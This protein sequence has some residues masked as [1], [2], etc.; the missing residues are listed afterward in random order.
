WIHIAFLAGISLLP[1]STGLVSEYATYRIPFVVYWLNLVF[2]GLMLLISV[3]YAR[4]AGLL[5]AEATQQVLEAL[6][7]RIYFYQA[8]Y[9]VAVALCGVT[10][11]ASLVAL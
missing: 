4:R 6:R 3:S 1:F 8:C 10:A 9:A 7:R 2:L 11:Y 5:K